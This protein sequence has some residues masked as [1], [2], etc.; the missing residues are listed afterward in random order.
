VIGVA[1]HV[2]EGKVVTYLLVSL[3]DMSNGDYTGGKAYVKTN[4][5]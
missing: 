4:P 2:R 1:N 3:S 5:G